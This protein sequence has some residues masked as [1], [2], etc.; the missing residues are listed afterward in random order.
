MHAELGNSRLPDILRVRVPRG[1]GAAIDA[2]ARQQ[3]T[4]SSEY[5]RRAIFKALRTDG[6]RLHLDG[7]VTGPEGRP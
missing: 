5:L 6:V 4:S 1:F 2:A 3:F 7:N